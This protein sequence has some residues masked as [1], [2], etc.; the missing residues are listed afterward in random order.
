MAAFFFPLMGERLWGT[1]AGLPD[2]GPVYGAATAMALGA[3]VTTQIGNLF[4]QRTE[5]ASFFRT[6]LS[7]TACSGSA[8]LRSWSWCSC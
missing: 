8:L 2:A 1:M 4:A 6:P 3:V 7:V 5:R